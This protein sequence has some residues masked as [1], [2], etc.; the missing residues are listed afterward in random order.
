MGDRRSGARAGDAG[1]TDAGA[2]GPAAGCTGTSGAGTPDAPAD[3]KA[4]HLIVTG[5][6][7]GVFY[8]ASTQEQGEHMGLAGWVRNRPDGSVEAHVQGPA[9]QVDV[10]VEWC[11]SGPP[12]AAV[13]D[14]TCEPATYDTTLTRFG[15]RP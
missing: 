15:I 1:E 10:L 2:D 9:R 13:D 11:R 4:V 14:V 5:R 6:V 7:Q 12:M 8:R 3:R